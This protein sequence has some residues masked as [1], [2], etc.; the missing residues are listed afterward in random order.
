MEHNIILKT[1]TMLDKD[2]E[3][4]FLFSIKT[5]G[6][7]G[8]IKDDKIYKSKNK[9]YFCYRVELTRD[10]LKDEAEFI[11]YYWDFKFDQDYDIEITQTDINDIFSYD[12]DYAVFPD[13]KSKIIEVASRFLHNRWVDN[14]I[15]NGW[16][17]GL[18]YNIRNKTDPKLRDWDSL[19]QEYRKIPNMNDIQLVNFYK[20]NRN[21]FT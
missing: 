14:K 21:L 12:I 7:E 10:L 6:P 3:E 19:P 2:Q 4:D 9:K 16:R 11:I 17:Y 8:I 18:Y 13:A 5:H 1:K 15:K 20:K